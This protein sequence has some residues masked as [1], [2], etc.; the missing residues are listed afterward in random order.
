[1]TADRPTLIE[2]A[3]SLARSGKCANVTALKAALH[4]EGY[5]H[6]ELAQW[7]SALGRELNKICKAAR[8]ATS[9]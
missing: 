1:M 3:Y 8:D 9:G 5:T 7:G 2:R 6:A 4:R